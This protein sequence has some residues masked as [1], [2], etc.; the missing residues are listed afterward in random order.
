MQRNQ[1]LRSLQESSFATH[2]HVQVSVFWTEANMR[3]L[4]RACQV[5]GHNGGQIL[6]IHSDT[7]KICNHILNVEYILVILCLGCYT[8]LIA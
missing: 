4:V 7:F 8:F 3:M 5:H 6:W 2:L 1:C